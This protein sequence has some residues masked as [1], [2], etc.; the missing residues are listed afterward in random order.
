MAVADGS[1][2]GWSGRRLL[3]N[4]VSKFVGQKRPTTGRLGCVLLVR[5]DDVISRSKRAGVKD[6][7]RLA[8]SG[9]V[10][11]AHMLKRLS[12]AWLKETPTGV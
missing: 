9:I 5:K 12:E 7:S 10:V 6:S 1:L 2:H 3:L 8:R 11:N 4:G